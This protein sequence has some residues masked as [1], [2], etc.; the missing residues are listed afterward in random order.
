MPV[1]AGPAPQVPA[2]DPSGS[3]RASTLSPMTCRR[4][5]LLPATEPFDRFWLDVGDGHRLHVRQ[6]GRVDGIPAV[7]IHGGPGSGD[8]GLLPRFFDPGRYRIICPDQRGSGRS[9]PRG[10]IAD[11]DTAA[12]V[13]DL[14]RLRRHLGIDHWLVVGGSWGAT[15]ALCHAAADPAAISGLLLRGSFLARDEDL[16]W[17]FQGARSVRPRSWARLAATA[18][19][20]R[21]ADLLGWLASALLEGPQ[22]ERE[23]AAAAWAAWE[24]AMTRPAADDDRLTL[25]LSGDGSSGTG[26]GEAV[27]PSR[28]TVDRFRIQA[29]YLVHRCWL[30]PPDT[31]L[32]RCARVPAVPTRLL[33]GTDD[34]ICRPEGA[35]LLQARLPAGAELLWLEGAGHDPTHPRITDAMVRATDAFA[36]HGRFEAP[37]ATGVDS[38]DR[39]F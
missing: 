26:A 22:W 1:A 2:P 33:H 12:G 14:T 5:T 31:L 15:L 9:E 10:A 37:D 8:S 24:A 34:V 3:R 13:V 21:E 35:V 25:P 20:G 38:S 29:H 39:A 23:I 16:H 11:N 18:P 27:A 36:A 17:F 6:F 7:A 30:S 4:R 19:A 32:A 28:A